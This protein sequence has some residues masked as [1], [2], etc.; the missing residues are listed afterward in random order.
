[1]A[2]KLLAAL[3]LNKTQRTLVKAGVYDSNGN[4]TE[5]GK[6]LVLN[7]LAGENESK[8]VELTKDIVEKSKNK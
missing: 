2:N 3:K 8:L 7:Y 6:E 1:M 4:L 5:D